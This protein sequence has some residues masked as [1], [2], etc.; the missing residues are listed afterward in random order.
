MI[1][2]ERGKGNARN[3]GER[4]QAAAGGE[5]VIRGGVVDGEFP[6]GVFVDCDVSATPEEERDI[7]HE[8]E[9]E[10]DPEPDVFAPYPE[11]EEVLSD[12]AP[13]LRVETSVLYKE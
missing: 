7:G 1:S 2:W 11:T 4:T 9:S 8:R 6:P 5:V 13:V 3:H 10:R 12:P